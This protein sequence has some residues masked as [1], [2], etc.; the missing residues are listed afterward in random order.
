MN[1]TNLTR[2]IHY[3]C[4]SAILSGF[5]TYILMLVRRGGLADKVEPGMTVIVKLSAM[6]LYALAICQLFLLVESVRADPERREEECGCNEL[7]PSGIGVWLKY[8]IFLLPLVFGMLEL[9]RL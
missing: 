5:A 4:R 7:P 1:N 9:W 8:G 2:A 6:G 3:G